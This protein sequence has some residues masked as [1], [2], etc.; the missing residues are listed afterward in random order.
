MALL[1]IGSGRLGAP[2]LLHG[3][4]WVFFAESAK[5][6]SA[7]RALAKRLANNYR[8][9][10]VR[11]P[12]SF[13]REGGWR[14]SLDNRVTAFGEG[15]ASHE[16]SPIHYPA[17]IPWIGNTLRDYGLHKLTKELNHLLPPTD[18][19]R[20]IVCYDSPSQYS[21]IGTLGE[22]LSVYLAIDDRTVTVSGEPIRGEVEAE[23]K[24][25][26]R[27]D[28]VICVSSTLAQTL[29]ERACDRDNLPI[30]VLTN[31]YDESLFTPDREWDEPA[32]L[33]HVPRPRIL[34]AGHISERLD[35]DG[36]RRASELRPTWSW[37]FVGPADSGIAKRIA[38]IRANNK[39]NALQF[40]PVAYADVPAWIA[41]CDACAVPYRL[42]DFTRASSPLKAIECLAGGAPILSTRVPSL[43]SFGDVIFWVAEG[44]GLSYANA[45]DA[46]SREERFGAT[47]R[48]RGEA[49]RS[50]NWKHK[51][52]KFCRLLSC[53]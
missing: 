23:R 4:E 22:Q 17:R 42:N 19:A 46:I 27:V 6:S 18:F 50:E 31:G 32:E 20:R 28:H 52:Q 26:A 21:L 15:G 35:W 9:I 43:E 51:T 39:I 45:L 30:D 44:D 16:Y 38:S 2:D 48:R 33:R 8:V 12:I 11:Q 1:T 53:S 34:I 36:I 5:P 41:H 10:V 37:V 13:L 24:L 14:L 49:V 47:A 40:P 29:R 3:V 25:L 7:R